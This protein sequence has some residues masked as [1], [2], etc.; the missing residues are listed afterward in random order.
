MDF[1]NIHRSGIISNRDTETEETRER[2]RPTT[3]HDFLTV[4]PVPPPAYPS[5][6]IRPH[7]PRT[8]P[9]RR[10]HP[11][12]VPPASRTHSPCR[13]IFMASFVP[14]VSLA[15]HR[16]PSLER[17]R[18]QRGARR[19][20]RKKGKKKNPNSIFPRWKIW[21]QRRSRGSNDWWKACIGERP[22]WNTD[23]R[24]GRE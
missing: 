4:P 20:R 12:Y 10:R 11:P 21:C 15:T 19:K 24:A 1:Y 17:I 7:L 22:T 5:R 16:A 6:R 3:S 2:I 8:L 23:R 9:P 13:S 18:I 14:I